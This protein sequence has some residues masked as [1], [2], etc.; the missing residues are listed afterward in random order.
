M[1]QGLCACK[2]NN[3]LSHRP[4]LLSLLPC[5]LVQQSPLCSRRRG[6]KIRSW[7]SIT[8]LP[9]RA[10]LHFGI[11]LSFLFPQCSKAVIVCF[12]HI[13]MASI[14][15]MGFINLLLLFNPVAA[16]VGYGF[17]RPTPTSV[18]LVEIQPMVPR[19]T[20]PPSMDEINVELRKR[21]LPDSIFSAL[22]KSW[23]AFIEGD[24]GKFE[25]HSSSHPR[26]TK[27]A[28]IRSDISRIEDPLTCR[29]SKTCTFISSYIYT[30][31]VC[32]PYGTDRDETTSLFESCLDYR[33]WL[34]M[35][36]RRRSD[37]TVWLECPFSYSSAVVILLLVMLKRT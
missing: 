18:G 36:T 34:T 13:A 22:P 33:K 16:T 20:R 11:H 1:G 29:S 37:T 5:F 32:S 27:K 24:T 6:W 12:I 21:R 3:V 17:I 8:A 19:P 10:V 9:P 30:S 26:V 25:A 23:C 2:E 35:S 14:P 31:I 4:H 15:V 7:T 28:S